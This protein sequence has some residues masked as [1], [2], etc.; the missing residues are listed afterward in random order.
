MVTTLTRVKN[1]KLLRFTIFSYLSNYIKVL[2]GMEKEGSGLPIGFENYSIYQLGE[3]NKD[4]MHK[5]DYTPATKDVTESAYLDQNPALFDTIIAELED[6]VMAR[7]KLAMSDG[8]L[9][10]YNILR[11]IKYQATLTCKITLLRAEEAEVNEQGIFLQGKSA[12]QHNPKGTEDVVFVR[13]NGDEY[14][15]QYII[16]SLDLNNAVWLRVG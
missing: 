3:S 11:S 13:N 7:A 4:Q 1:P 12:A 2:L 15:R 10:A 16:V 9:Y 8:R 6:R 14:A 5:G